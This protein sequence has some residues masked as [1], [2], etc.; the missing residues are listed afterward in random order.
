MSKLLLGILFFCL[1]V[2][3]FAQA[4]ASSSSYQPGIVT[5]VKPHQSTDTSD[6]SQRLYEVSVKVN[7]TTYVVL[8]TP[9]SGESTMLYVVGREVLVQ[10]G[11]NVIIWNDI[12]GQSH[13]VPIIAR[14]P[15]MTGSNAHN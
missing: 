8:T 4:S 15:I 5:Q 1:P 14:G 9:P 6:L 10:V 2:L 3:V 7:G 13:Q 11:D 12:L